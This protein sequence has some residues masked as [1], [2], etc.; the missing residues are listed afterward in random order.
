MENSNEPKQNGYEDM[1]EEMNFE[2]AEI[3]EEASLLDEGT[4]E[5]VSFEQADTGDDLIID[6]EY[7]E[8]VYDEIPHS[9]IEHDASHETQSVPNFILYE[10]SQEQA[11][12][13]KK[14]R[15]QKR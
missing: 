2:N 14:A 7:S 3:I 1:N 4:S 10:Q 8:S 12:A 9:R 15:K 6:A 5:E 13:P 11:K